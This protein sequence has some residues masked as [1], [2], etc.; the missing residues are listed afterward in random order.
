MTP[1][2]NGE[3]LEM[4]HKPVCTKSKQSKGGSLKCIVKER[5]K[6]LLGN[7]MAIVAFSAPIG[8]LKSL[9]GNPLRS[10]PIELYLYI[11]LLVLAS[12]V[13]I[14]FDMIVGSCIGQSMW[15]H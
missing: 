3:K 12:L 6:E 1:W 7:C 14:L 10:L 11:T 5:W 8:L 9:D 2:P 15:L 4:H 13:G